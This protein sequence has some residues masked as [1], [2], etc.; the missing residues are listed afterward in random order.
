MKNPEWHL[1]PLARMES[2]PMV[3]TL[4]EELGSGLSHYWKIAEGIL[5]Q[6][7]VRLKAPVK[8]D[9]PLEKNFFSFLFLYSFYRAGIPKARRI[10][11]AAVLQCFRGMVTGCDNLLDDEYKMTLDTD[12]P[13]KAIKFRSV[14]DIMVSDRVLFLILLEACRHREIDVEKVW[15]ATESSMKTI[16]RSGLQEASEE[17]GITVIL[18]PEDLLQTVHH[19][20]TGLLF[21][22]SWDIPLAL[23]DIDES[24]ISPLLEGLYRIGMGCQIMD[25]MVDF[26]SDLERKRHN[27][28]VSLIYYSPCSIEKNRLME[29]VAERG[30]KPV[31]VDLAK[32]FPENLLKALKTSHR[33]LGEGLD[34]L[35]SGRERSLEEPCI[36]FLEKRLGV[37]R[38][39]GHQ[40]HEI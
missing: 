37:A 24:D 36:R 40:D 7:G 9:F 12:I 17:G 31:T 33:F 16:T 22:C 20:K 5:R 23:E 18:K 3:R 6:S 4:L 26:M 2:V 25:D 38:L 19:Y 30:S 27:F 14:M 8:D 39:F 13:E 10:L 1:N 28:L 34:L 15:A 35:F 11:Y 29:L 32:D 21:K